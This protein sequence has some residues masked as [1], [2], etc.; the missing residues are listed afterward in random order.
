M[1]LKSRIEKRLKALENRHPELL[2]GQVWLSSK[3]HPNWQAYNI[4]RNVVGARTIETY[5]RLRYILKKWNECKTPNEIKLTIGTL[6]R[7]HNWYN[8]EKILKQE[9]GGSNGQE[10]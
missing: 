1:N 4:A 3:D 5:K 7:Y 10:I 9:M 6:M 2:T 8:Y